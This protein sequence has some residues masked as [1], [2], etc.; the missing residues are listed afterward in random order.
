MTTIATLTVDL[1]A[2][3]AKFR[4][5]L[6]K[7]NKDANDWSTKVR[8]AATSA[9]KSIAGL[10]VASAA[11]LAAMYTVTAQA[12]DQ[13]TKFADKIGISTEALAGLQHAGELTGV[14]ANTMNMGL[15]RMT[16]RI[17]EAAQGTG[18]AVG[19]LDQ[20][21]LS[22]QELNAMNPDE[23]F[24]AIAGAMGE[25][26]SRS[27]QVR[28]AF[29]LFDSEGVAL[30]NTLD[31]G[32]EG[33]N[34]MMTEAEM[35]GLTLSRID[36]QKV[37]QANDAF[38]KATKISTG[39]NR[40]LTAELAPIVEG[41]STEF[42]QASLNAGGMGEVATKAADAIVTALDVVYTGLLSLQNGWN[43]IKWAT[44]EA[45][46]YG[47]E[48][49]YALEVNLKGFLN[50]LPGVEV[51]MSKH[52]GSVVGF[53]REESREAFDDMTASTKAFG[54]QMVE[55]FNGAGAVKELTDQWRLEAEANAAATV[56]QKKYNEAASDIPPVDEKLQ[57]ELAKIQQSY[58]D[59]EQLLLESTLKEQDIIQQALNNRLLSEQEAQL[60]SQESWNAYYEQMGDSNLGFWD[61]MREHIQNTATDFD[62]MWG[63]A[64][65]NFTSGVGDAF[66][67]AIVDGNNFHD[68]MDQ[69]AKG[70]AKSMISALVQIGAQR[71]ALWAM[72]KMFG[73][74]A[75]TGYA[76]QVAGQ[77]AAGV[78]LAGINAYAS[79]AAIPLIGP[80]LAPG[81][82]AAAIATTTPM[83][84]AATAAA[85]S[86]IAGMAH[87]GIDT[88]PREG[89][90]LLD[91]GE[92]VVDSRTNA[93]LKNYL[94]NSG[95]EQQAQ[96]ITYS[97]TIVVE[98]GAS[99][100]ADQAFA[101]QIINEV[102]YRLIEDGQTNGPVK[103]TMNGSRYG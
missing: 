83:A 24:K 35:L 32:K 3:S 86:S 52:L 97:P 26:N 61:Q 69:I 99:Q 92:R 29:K 1:L 88:I 9:A 93:D 13:Q 103:R 45:A 23:Q 12:I 87:D 34:G 102:F 10:G 60:L 2:E 20:L 96:P 42:L 80:V 77:S 44:I 31:A 22:A 68:A 43:V 76:T 16:R 66:A 95:G 71:A 27:E 82:M 41:V 84:A 17:A 79:T 53:L 37:E 21:G 81:A 40:L 65:N 72:E 58:A 33:I 5:E 64:F 100:D 94:R 101:E 39:F 30:L 62:A 47:V 48:A 28:L 85:T 46:R 36:A 73:T 14:A 11:G 51:E 38:D 59:K 15:Q 74:A 98:S 91:K 25:V 8:G 6:K 56:A 75:A 57:A 90:W 70:F 54:N 19:A 49:L 55:V 18:E 78:Q 50:S 4:S 67:D 63:N 89:T 7:A